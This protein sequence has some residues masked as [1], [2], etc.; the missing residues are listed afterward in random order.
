[1]FAEAV[2][3]FTGMM[4]E[5]VGRSSDDSD[6][7]LDLMAKGLELYRDRGVAAARR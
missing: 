7:A 1:M 3:L 2:E 6:Q 5:R 4:E